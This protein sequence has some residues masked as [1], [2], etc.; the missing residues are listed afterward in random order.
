MKKLYL[1]RHAHTK[2]NEEE[3]YSGYSDTELSDTGKLQ[4]KE[5]NEFLKK[6]IKVDK[7]YSSILKRTGKTIAEYADSQN[8]EL[9][10]LEGLNEMNFGNFDG[11]SLNEIKARYPKDYENF[12]IGK[13][14]FKFPEGENIER[15]YDRNIKAFKSIIEDNKDVDTVMICAHMG[16]LRN[17]ISY[18]LVDNFSIHWNIRIENATITVIEFMESFPVLK[19]LGYIPYDMELLRPLVGK[20]IVKDV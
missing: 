2:D 9:E 20:K 14:D 5:L 15:F 13:V 11:L 12:M 18:L 6:N 17:I 7:I 3:K 10:K 8:I 1:I 4:A 16:T 19:M